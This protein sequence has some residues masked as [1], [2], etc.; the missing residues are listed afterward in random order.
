MANGVTG[1]IRILETAASEA[2]RAVEQEYWA[3]AFVLDAANER[4]TGY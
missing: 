4:P 2:R 1:T 3:T